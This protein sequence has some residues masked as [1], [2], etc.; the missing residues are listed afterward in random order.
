MNPVARSAHARRFDEEAL[1]RG[2]ASVRHPLP[3]ALLVLT[4]TTGIVDG[5]SYLGLGRVFT[6]NMTGNVVLLG[7]GI[8]GS[9]GLPVIGPVTSLVAFVL[10]TLAGGAVARRVPEPERARVLLRR[11]L[12]IEV[13]VLAVAAV[14]AGVTTP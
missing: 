8:A 6:A 11:E 14:V 9:G 3:R 1:K 4:F 13:T 2:V 7:F 5:V 10:G 12:A